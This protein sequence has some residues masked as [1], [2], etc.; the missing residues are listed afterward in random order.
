MPTGLLQG[1]PQGQCLSWREQG[2]D[3]QVSPGTVGGWGGQERE[4][5]LGERASLCQVEETVWAKSLRQEKSLA[6]CLRHGET[7][8]RVGAV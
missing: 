3:H 2:L 4:G 8:D 5:G 7:G 1:V 6:A